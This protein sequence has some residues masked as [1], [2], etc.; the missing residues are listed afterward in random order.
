MTQSVGGFETWPTLGSS[1]WVITAL[2]VFLSPYN[3]MKLNKSLVQPHSLKIL[4][5][6]A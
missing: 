4:D 3:F 2:A 1:D 6:V 5:V